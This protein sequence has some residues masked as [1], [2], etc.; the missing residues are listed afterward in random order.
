MAA[1][2]VYDPVGPTIEVD[3]YTYPTVKVEGLLVA[4]AYLHNDAILPHQVRG[5]LLQFFSRAQVADVFSE[6]EVGLEDALEE[7]GRRRGANLG[8]ASQGRRGPRLG[9]K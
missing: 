7:F 6:E 9:E 3:G 4:E 5:N 8:S 2:M 1:D